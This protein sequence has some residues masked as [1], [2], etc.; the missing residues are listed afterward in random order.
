MT[1]RISLRLAAFSSRQPL[2]S[3]QS[4][5]V[6]GLKYPSASAARSLLVLD[7]VPSEA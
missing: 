2:V 5:T 6:C 1:P 7:L 3:L 4:K